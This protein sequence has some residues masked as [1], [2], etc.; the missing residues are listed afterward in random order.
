MTGSEQTVFVVEDDAA[1]RDSIGLLLGIK[2]YRTQAFECAED[3]L[4]VYEA[5][6][7]GCLLLD[8]RMPGMS[9]LQLQEALRQK[10]LAL[11]IVIM[12]A[13]GDV[14][15]VRATLKSGAIDFLEKPVDPVALVAAIQVALGVD[16]TQ[17]RAELA[18]E[19]AKQRLDVLTV[20]ERQVMELIVTG[21]SNREIAKTLGISPR[22]VEVHKYR[23][24]EKLRVENLPALVQ[25]VVG[26]LATP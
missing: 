24:M 23:I 8:I 9:G 1:V 19:Q 21:L 3:F 11:P 6:W 20:R 13:H 22:T 26:P 25:F 5:T 17:R 10:N 16:A 14:S 18:A 2:G 15:T 7:G 12:T 4:R